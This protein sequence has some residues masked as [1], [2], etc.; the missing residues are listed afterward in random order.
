M[1]TDLKYILRRNKTTLQEFIVYN[2]L[3]TYSDLLRVCEE[4]KFIP[5]PEDEFNLLVKKEK[6]KDEKPK[7]QTRKTATR[8]TTSARGRTSS[9]Q[10]K[11]SSSTSSKKVKDT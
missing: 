1:K 11:R 10:K 7:K 5:I 8:K 2:E 3:Q 6:V 4:R 9:P